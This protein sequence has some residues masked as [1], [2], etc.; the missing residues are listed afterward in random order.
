MMWHAV[1]STFKKR[2]VTTN[3]LLSFLSLLGAF[4]LNVIKRN[5]SGSTLAGNGLS[6]VVATS[7]HFSEE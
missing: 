4:Q 6:E 7:L 1:V 5:H 2:G 3:G